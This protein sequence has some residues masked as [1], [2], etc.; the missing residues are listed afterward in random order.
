MPSE[1]VDPYVYPGTRVLKNLLGVQNAKELSHKEYTLT[2]GRRAE[3]QNGKVPATRFDLSHLQ[4][5]HHHL[6]QDVYD[7]AGEL[8]TVEISKGSSHFHPAPYIPTAAQYTFA[9]LANGD[10]LGNSQISDATFVEQLAEVFTLLNEIH[11][12]REGNGRAARAF[13][14]QVAARS[15][16]T[17]SWRNVGHDEWLRASIECFNAKSGEPVRPLIAKALQPPLDGLDPFIANVYRV[18]EPVIG[19]STTRNTP[20][21]R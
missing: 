4:A 16:R 12:F 20:T 14:D 15:N 9:V 13:L 18:S 17:L 2:L 5:L 6:F 10:L 1:F 21:I 19:S 3:I 11:P 8:R 7:W